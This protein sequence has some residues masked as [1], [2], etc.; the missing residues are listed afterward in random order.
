MET[1]SEPMSEGPLKNARRIVVKVG[2]SLVTYE[3]QWCG[4]ARPSATGLPAAGGAGAPGGREVVM[5]SS[6]GA[7]AEGH[8]APGLG[9]P[10]TTELHGAAGR[11]GGRARWGLVQMYE[12]QALAAHGMGSAQVLLTHADLADRERYLNA[13]STL[14]T[15][16]GLQRDPGHQRERHGR[17]RRDQVRRQRH[18]GRA[19]GQP[20]RGRRAGDPDDDQR[21]LVRWQTRARTRPPRFVDV[22]GLRPGIPAL[23]QMAGGAGSARG[24]GRHADQDPGGDD[25]ATGG[26]ASTAIA[27]G[28]VGGRAVAPG[29]EGEAIGTAAAG[30]HAQA[31][32]AQ[33]ADGRPSAAARRGA[34]GRWGC[35]QVAASEGKS[36]LP[37]GVI[38]GRAASS[39]PAGVIRGAQPAR[40]GERPAGLAN[41]SGCRG[42]LVIAPQA[43]RAQIGRPA[44]LR[45]RAASRSTATTCVLS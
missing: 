35:G 44:G 36:L 34:G 33:A 4:R 37:I 45:Q 41:Y 17:Q 5:A 9:R 24:H 38:R 40:P 43:L 21:G 25:A 15:L 30:R 18:P 26:G 10:A 13:R 16:L 31:G 20:G 29:G 12:T 14:L 7:I 27:W 1:A 2:S 6:G 23:E 22:P 39:T 19:G 28:R 11:G 3:G 42:A 8:E 32:G